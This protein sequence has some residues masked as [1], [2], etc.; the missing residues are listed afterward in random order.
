M[1]LLKFS[2]HHPENDETLFHILKGGTFLLRL[3]TL[4]KLKMYKK[5]NNNNSLALQYEKKKLA[6]VRVRK[7]E[8]VEIVKLMNGYSVFIFDL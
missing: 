2:V 4:L 7:S 5:N 1:P 6:I 8:D 3:F